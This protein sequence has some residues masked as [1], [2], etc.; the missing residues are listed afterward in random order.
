VPDLEN[1]LLYSLNRLEAASGTYSYFEGGR[2]AWDIDTPC[3][4]EKGA[5]EVVLRISF[6]NDETGETRS[7]SWTLAPRD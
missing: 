2:L 4:S 7:E 6:E 5:P 3:D 1:S